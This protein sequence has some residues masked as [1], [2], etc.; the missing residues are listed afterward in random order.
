MRLGPP[1]F[2][3]VCKLDLREEKASQCWEYNEMGLV[4]AITTA[5]GHEVAVNGVDYDGGQVGKRE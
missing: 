4:M 2:P 3:H 1:M 5:Q